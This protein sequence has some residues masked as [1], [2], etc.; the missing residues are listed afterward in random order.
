MHSPEVLIN[1]V[2]VMLGL[3]CALRAGE[4]HRALQSP[5]VNSQFEFLYHYNGQLYFKYKEDVGNKTNKGGIKQCKLEPKE[6]Y[7]YQTI[8][9]SHCSV[10]IINYYLGLLPEKRTC[11]AFYLQP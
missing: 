4:E 11:K 2:V 7:V 8:D 10:C 5:P 3:S 6:V 9:S 1:T